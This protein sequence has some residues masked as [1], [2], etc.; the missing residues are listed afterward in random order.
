MSTAVLPTTRF[1]LSDPDGAGRSLLW[2]DGHPT[3]T[4]IRGS[5]LRWQFSLPKAFVLITDYDDP[6]EEITE[7][8]LLDTSLKTIGTA[9]LGGGGTAF[10]LSTY[11]VKDIQWL[12]QH[13]FVTVPT[14]P[15]QGQFQ[16][17][18]RDRPFPVMGTRL[19]V[20]KY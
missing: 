12:D 7:I 4:R 16:I 5:S 14:T 18:V 10:A 8:T 13:S 20:T 17:A 9:S 11:Q 19:K 2:A 6:W 15:E 3:D 1:S